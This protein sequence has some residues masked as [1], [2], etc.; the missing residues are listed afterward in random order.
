MVFSEVCSCLL[1]AIHVNIR[2]ALTSQENTNIHIV[3]AKTF[4]THVIIPV[5]S[6]SPNGRES[7]PPRV[8]VDGG[9]CG[10]AGVAFD[11][12]GEWLYS[13]TERTVVEWDMRR[14]G[15][16]EGGGWNMA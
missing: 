3:D 14:W 8:G 2:S 7:P 10:I 6:Y 15:G 11:P 1:P 5:P 12:T 16:G 13:G 4:N 9:E